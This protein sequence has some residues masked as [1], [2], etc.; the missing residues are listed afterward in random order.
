MFT[1]HAPVDE[2]RRMPR[3]VVD[4]I[5]TRV[6]VEGDGA[7]DYPR[8]VALST[9]AQDAIA[10]ARDAR[11]AAA[12]EEAAWL[13]DQRLTDGEWC[14]LAAAL[15]EPEVIAAVRAYFSFQYPKKRPHTAAAMAKHARLFDEH[16]ALERRPAEIAARKFNDP[17]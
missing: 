8:P 1:G 4:I 6:S 11:A 13:A 15:C 12:A 5:S 16:R 17:A 9:G 10:A 7:A 14:R 2:D 3:L